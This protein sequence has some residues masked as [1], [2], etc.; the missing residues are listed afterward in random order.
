[1]VLRDVAKE[2]R[3]L[4]DFDLLQTGHG[5]RGVLAHTISTVRASLSL[6][7]REPVV[8]GDFD[9]LALFAETAGGEAAVSKK[10]GEDRLRAKV[11]GQQIQQRLEAAE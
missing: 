11:A 8:D 9:K 6:E 5:G 10:R 2:N 7:P 1:M 4:L 3:E